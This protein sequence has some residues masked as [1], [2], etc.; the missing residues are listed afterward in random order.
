MTFFLDAYVDSFFA[1]ELALPPWAVVGVWAVLFSINHAL[2]RRSQALVRAQS[3]LAAADPV[4]TKGAAHVALQV[5]FAVI[6][7][8]TSC[9]LGP[10]YF[11]FFGGGLIVAM[12]VTVGLNIHS[13]AFSRALGIP[14]NAEGSLKLSPAFVLRTK[15]GQLAGAG[16]ACLG[17]AAL[18]PHLALAGGSFFLWASAYG[19]HRRANKAAAR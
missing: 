9:V 5:A 10:G 13:V 7:L 17:I 6:V 1:S 15:S 16:V 2:F 14:G 8:V 19:F 12:A 4:A 3:I 18:V 11:A